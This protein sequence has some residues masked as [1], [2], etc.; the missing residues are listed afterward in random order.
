MPEVLIFVHNSVE[1]PV[2]EMFLLQSSTCAPSGHRLNREGRSSA[3]PKESMTCVRTLI[4][5]K[6]IMFPLLCT[7]VQANVKTL[8]KTDE[9][10]QVQ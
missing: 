1:H 6:N 8:P 2:V 3:S 9:A 4:T 5:M 7:H 10:L